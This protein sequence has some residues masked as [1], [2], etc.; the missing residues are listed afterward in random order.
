MAP[1]VYADLTPALEPCSVR[2]ALMSRYN[3]TKRA[4]RRSG[5]GCFK[6][7]Q[8]LLQPSITYTTSSAT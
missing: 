2:M 5:S 3:F 1:N 7:L 4:I 6:S 8:S